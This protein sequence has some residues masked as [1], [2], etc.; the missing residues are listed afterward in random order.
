MQFHE[1]SKYGT[2]YDTGHDSNS[3]I[4]RNKDSDDEEDSDYLSDANSKRPRH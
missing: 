1:C 2:N 4:G 3:A